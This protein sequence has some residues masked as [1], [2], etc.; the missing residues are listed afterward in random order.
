LLTVRRMQQ[1]VALSRERNFTR[2]ASL[3]G[4]TQPALS[5]AVASL[6]DEAGLILFE[7]SASGTSPTPAGEALIDEAQRILSS[8][9]LAEHN[10]R[11]RG[12]GD[13]GQ[14]SL[15]VGPLAATSML[16]NILSRTLEAAPNLSVTAVVRVTSAIIDGVLDGSF[17]FGICSANTMTPNP[18]IEVTMLTRLPMGIFVRHGHPLLELTRNITWE[19]L[20]AFP[21]MS[22]RFPKEARSGSAGTFGPLERSVECNDF[23]VLRITALQT[24]AIWLTAKV[25]AESGADAGK[26]VELHTVPTFDVE[27][28]ELLMVRQAGRVLSPAAERVIKVAL[29]LAS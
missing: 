9:E 24:D 2:A 3:L 25:L 1:L 28:A 12:K 19:D 13:I 21:R 15:A 18:E 8:V 23:E 4:M 16:A 10:V 11:M 20:L 5:R 26:F 29:S 7:R 27:W 22:G 17:D 14:V 6:E